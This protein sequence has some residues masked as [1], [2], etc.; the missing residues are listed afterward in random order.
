MKEELK[1]IP[2][3]I[4]KVRLAPDRE[5]KIMT[6]IITEENIEK[7]VTDTESEVIEAK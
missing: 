2:M 3:K 7:K 6:E 5:G 4:R 1:E